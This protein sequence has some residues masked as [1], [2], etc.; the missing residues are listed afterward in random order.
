MRGTTSAVVKVATVNV[1]SAA[2]FGVEARVTA[3]TGVGAERPLASPW[4]RQTG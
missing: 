2:A 4:E 1:S 3:A